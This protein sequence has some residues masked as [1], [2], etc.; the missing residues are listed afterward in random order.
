MLLKTFVQGG[1][2]GGVLFFSG[3]FTTGG[4]NANPGDVG[5][6]EDANELLE[7]SEDA[8]DSGFGGGYRPP[9]GIWQPEDRGT[10]GDDKL[11][12][13]D[14]SEEVEAL[15]FMMTEPDEVVDEVEETDAFDVGVIL[16]QESQ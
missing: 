1:V 16:V 7:L 11:A 14:I 8:T 2:V 9:Y 12:F 6:R 5:G 13:E 3:Q 10:G 4:D 15:G